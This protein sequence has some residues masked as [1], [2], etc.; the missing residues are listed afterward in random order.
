VCVC[1][2]VCLEGERGCWKSE[3]S[4]KDYKFFL[5]GILMKML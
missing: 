1:V 4:T 2:C 5:L 3:E